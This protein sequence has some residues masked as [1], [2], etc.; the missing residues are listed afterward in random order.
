[1]ALWLFGAIPVLAATGS[2]ACSWHGG[3]SCGAGSDWDGSVICKDGWRDSSVDYSDVCTETCKLGYM[4]E[5][6]NL[7][8]ECKATQLKNNG[9]LI[10][11]KNTLLEKKYHAIIDPLPEEL[12]V[13]SP[14]QQSSL[15]QQDAQNIQFQID[16]VIAKIEKNNHSCDVVESSKSLFCKDLLQIK[17]LTCP[18]HSSLIDDKCRCIDGFVMKDNACIS[19]TDDCRNAFGQNVY[20]MKGR[21]ENSTC[22]CLQGFQWDPSHSKCDLILI[23]SVT[24]TKPIISPPS[25]NIKSLEILQSTEGLAFEKSQSKRTIV[26]TYQKYRGFFVIQ[27]GNNRLWYIHP[28]DKKRYLIDSP[29]DLL[30]LLQKKGRFV[31][32][33]QLKSVYKYP[34]NYRGMLIVETKSG[35]HLYINPSENKIYDIGIKDA[36]L[37]YNR[38][39]LGFE[40]IKGLAKRLSDVE[41]RKVMVGDL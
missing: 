27:Q 1:M 19:H 25:S 9:I 2:G 33:K 38:F 14:T 41:I 39:D 32:A 16:A 35:T 17:Q 5:Y 6:Y 28:T 12:Q 13:L 3:V 18:V 37:G 21:D 36:L 24:D 11:Q 31:N 29:S 20:G 34:R 15:R 40:I 10:D 22:Y 23:T 8:A 30:S 7:L 4:D 26:K